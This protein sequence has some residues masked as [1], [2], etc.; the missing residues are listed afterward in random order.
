M[1]AIHVFWDN[2][3]IFIP[4]QY[5]A[6]KRDGAI[7]QSAVRIQFDNMYRL[8]SAGR[9]VTGAVCVGSVPPELKAVW[10]RLESAGVEI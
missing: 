6:L 7:L 10:N 1:P 3:N 4:A 8:A 9:E 5:V 2:S